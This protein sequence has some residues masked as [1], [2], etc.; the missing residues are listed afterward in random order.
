MQA[1]FYAGAFI[2]TYV[3][4]QLGKAHCKIKAF[5]KTFPPEET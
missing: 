3:L 4:I 2:V 1:L 5:Q